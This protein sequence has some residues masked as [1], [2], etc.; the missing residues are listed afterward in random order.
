MIGT[1]FNLQ[2]LSNKPKLITNLVV[3]Q[4]LKNGKKGFNLKV[5]RQ[6]VYQGRVKAVGISLSSYVTK[7]NQVDNEHIFFEITEPTSN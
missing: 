5:R 3:C 7:S 6:F 1:N 4:N 2:E